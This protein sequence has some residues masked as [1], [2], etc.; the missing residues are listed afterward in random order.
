MTDACQILR[1]GRASAALAAAALVGWT[2]VAAQTTP[3]GDPPAVLYVIEF[4]NAI[5]H[6]AEISATFSG[7]PDGPLAVVM[8]RSSPG[9]YSLHE[10]A[11]NVYG[12]RA[13]DGAGHPLSVTRAT[14]HE[15]RV[16]GHDGTVRISYTVFADRAGGTNSGI[17]ATHAHLNMPATF[18]WARGFAKRPIRIRLRPPPGSG[19]R[20]ATQLAPTDDAYEF[21]APD[22]Q[23]FM[24]SPAELSDFSY[25]EWTVDGTGPSRRIRMAVHHRGT[26]AEL[27]AYAELAKQVVIEEM[28]VFG[29]LPEFDYGT[30]TFIADYLPYAVGD[31]MEHRNSTL[32]TGTEP[33]STSTLGH[34]FTLAH[35]FF[36]AWNMER[37]RSRGIEPFDFE[38]AN[39]SDALWFGEG[40][41]S[42]YDDL[43]LARAGIIDLDAY[44]DGLGGRIESVLTTPARRWRGPIDMSRQAPFQDRASFLAPGN[45]ANTFLSYYTYGSAL[46][47]AL[48][49]T[50]RGRFPA[51]SLDDLMREMWTAHGKTGVPYAIGDIEAALAKVTADTSFARDFFDRFIRGRKAPDFHRLLERAGLV[52][53]PAHPGAASAGRARIEFPDG[54]A[55]IA[56]STRVGSPLYEAGVDRG[57]WIVS[58]DGR[59]LRRGAD[60]DAVL[61]AHAPGDTVA[62]VFE[63]RDGRHETSL[64]LAPD[65]AL[66]VVT[67]EKA[68][69]EPTE[70]MLGFRR[71][72]LASKGGSR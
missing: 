57:D 40:F 62:L 26:D 54:R 65:P 6:E 17:D 5:H 58:L 52:V 1:T 60:L 32:L 14:P 50:L 44:A 39:M 67:F 9:R 59:D 64:V 16:S 25:R 41:T 7:V 8:S 30:Y 33:L 23:Y 43:V 27:D 22:L 20:V 29:E 12:F 69:R 2:P 45:E 56:S 13:L 35:E 72:W 3:T 70:A 19:W 37:I 66:E 34:L 11:R 53:R 24:D 15:W 42:Y 47:L 51:R 31:G 18:A 46:G 68:G 36:H 63:G 48:D 61:G 4:P 21:T 10:F 38:R 71:A 49:L 55:R 28:G